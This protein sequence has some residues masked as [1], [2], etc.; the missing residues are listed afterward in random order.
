MALSCRFAS[1]AMFVFRM[2][3]PPLCYLSLRLTTSSA[4]RLS[5][6]FPTPQLAPPCRLSLFP[7]RRPYLCTTPMIP[8]YDQ[9]ESRSCFKPSPVDVVIPRVLRDIERPK[10]PSCC[11]LQPHQPPRHYY[12]IPQL[13]TSQTPRSVLPLTKRS[14][15]SPSDAV[16]SIGRCTAKKQKQLR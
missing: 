12:Y 4:Y 6:F 7:C 10:A 9:A 11:F 14:F 1:R 5:L 15:A 16:Q 8:Q 3:K 2:A 13:P